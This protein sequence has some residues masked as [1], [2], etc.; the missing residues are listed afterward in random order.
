MDKQSVAQVTPAE[1]KTTTPPFSRNGKAFY[2]PVMLTVDLISGKWKLLLLWQLLQSKD[3]QG[4][5][6]YGELRKALIGISEKMLIQTLRELEA[7]ALVTR[8]VYSEVPPRVEY[9]LTEDGKALEKV[10]LALGGFGLAWKR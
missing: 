2:C 3:S 5:M 10:L 1:Q 8:T 4:V 6:R 9:A 7:D